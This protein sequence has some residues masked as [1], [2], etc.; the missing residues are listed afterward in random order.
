MKVRLLLVC[1]F[2]GSA[3][4]GVAKAEWTPLFD[5]KTLDGWIPKITKHEAGVNALDTFRI[6]DGILK[7]SYENYEKFDGQYGHLYTEK[8]Y[9]HYLIRMEY[10]FEGVMLEDAPH[11]VNL[12]SGF[13]VHSQS[14]HE[15]KR[16]QNFPISVEFQFL[17]D[18]GKGPRPT[19][20]VCTPGTTIEH[21]GEHITRHI[22]QS[23]AP[24]YPADKWVS[25]E[26]EVRG[27]ELIMHR[28]NG[29]EVLRYSA[30][31]LDP[32]DEKFGSAQLVAAGR[33]L[34]LDRGHIALQAEGQ[35]VWFRNIEIKELEP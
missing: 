28:V 20:N 21:N 10:R 18:E 1:L 5:G 22:V 24:N 31:K 2:W 14:A 26:M 6:E 19:G 23:S 25:V 3:M 11:F 9:S 4:S 8:S 27:D 34:K 12:N 32:T 13:M 35:G 15:M 33:P 16:D 7:V 30:T 17:A 29:V